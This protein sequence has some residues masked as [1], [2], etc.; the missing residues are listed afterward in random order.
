MVNQ[1]NEITHATVPQ[2]AKR[3]K[4]SERRVRQLLSAGRM[5]GIKTPNGRWYV[6]WPLQVTS[7]NRGPDMLNFPTRIKIKFAY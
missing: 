1:K 2:V 4:I 5:N 7:G 3:L 6:C